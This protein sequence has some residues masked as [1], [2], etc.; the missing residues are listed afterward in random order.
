LEYFENLSPLIE[1]T[2]LD[3]FQSFW[4][5]LVLFDIF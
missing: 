5:I 3:Y 2:L 4:H 1:L